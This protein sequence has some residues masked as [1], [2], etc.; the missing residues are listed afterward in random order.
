MR[1][2]EQMRDVINRG[3][4]Y[5]FVSTNDVPYTGFETMIFPCNEDGEVTN[6]GELYCDRYDTVLEAT[7]GHTRAINN[8][9]P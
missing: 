8:F 7:V 4:Q 6:W 3:G 9:Q 2:M 5:Y 1:R